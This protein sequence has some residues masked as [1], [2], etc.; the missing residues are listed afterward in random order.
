MSTRIVNWFWNGQGQLPSYYADRDYSPESVRLYSD[1]A[2]G[3]ICQVDIRTDGVSILSDYAGLEGQ[4]TVEDIAGNFPNSKVNI[5]QGSVI[6][7]HIISTGG[8]GTLNVQL[9]ME[10]LDE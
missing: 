2:P 6:T 4:Q 5:E 10:S 1:A 9:E 7:C 3:K 8:A